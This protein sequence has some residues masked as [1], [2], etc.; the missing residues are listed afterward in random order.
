MDN[1]VTLSCGREVDASDAVE[2]T[3]GYQRGQLIH[4]DDSVSTADGEVVHSDDAYYCD[5]DGEYYA[6]SS[7]LIHVDGGRYSGYYFSD[8]VVYAEDC[9]EYYH[10]NDIGRY[11]FLHS[12]GCYY[13]EEEQTERCHSYHSGSR[14]MLTTE[15]TKF[16]IGFEVEKEDEEV[17]ND[18]DLSDVDDTKWSREE[19]GSLNGVSGFELVSPTYDLMTDDLDTAVAT[20]ILSAHI[21]AKYSDNCGGHINFGIKGLDGQETYDKVK[22]FV[23]VLLSLYQ[24]RLRSRWCPAKKSY[25]NSK[26]SAVAIKSSYIEFRAPSAVISVTNLLWRRDLLRIMASNLDKGTLF[27]IREMLTPT[28]ELH[29][30]LLKVVNAPTIYRRAA[31]AAA[32][33][34]KMTGTDYAKYVSVEGF[35]SA[36]ETMKPRAESMIRE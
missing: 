20:D 19:D 6:D 13:T 14:P 8:D 34:E 31:F 2:I 10:V 22:G 12:D 17:L 36:V 5:G 4:V 30:H 32:L 33:A 21:N 18:W 27:F 3:C 11:V 25:D 23:P 26:Y 24:S 15:D 7:D 35:G 1:L 9:N 16:T 29:K 28:S